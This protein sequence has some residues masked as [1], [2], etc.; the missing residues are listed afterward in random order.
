MYI[1]LEGP[2][3][4]GKTS[5]IYYLE[6]YLIERDLDFII[7]REPGGS[8]LGLKLREMLKHTDDCISPKAELMLFLADRAQHL[9]TVVVPALEANKVVIS[10][11]CFLSTL[12]YQSYVR[13]TLGITDNITMNK[14]ICGPYMPDLIFVLDISIKEYLKRKKTN[15]QDKI[16][17]SISMA[18]VIEAYKSDFL[19]KH[20]KLRFVNAMRKPE[21]I[22][23][24]IIQEIEIYL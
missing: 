16:E 22:A 24:D 14:I 12:V 6:K 13:N 11:R 20:Y 4:A 8:S 5:Q 18:K 19:V 2:D 21:E 15:E 23:A 9:E 10:D 3:G 1:A 7:T 17:K